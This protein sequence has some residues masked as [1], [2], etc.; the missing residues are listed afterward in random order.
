MAGVA[1][2]RVAVVHRAAVVVD[3]KTTETIGERR[4]SIAQA[5]MNGPNRPN[6]AAPWRSVA[7]NSVFSPVEAV[8]AKNRSIQS[9]QEQ[10]RL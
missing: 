4:C 2:L 1:D 9:R 7:N 6:I 3:Q 5:L 8:L 10:K